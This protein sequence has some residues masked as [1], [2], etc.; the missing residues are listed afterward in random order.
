MRQLTDGRTSFY[1]CGLALSFR[2]RRFVISHGGAVE[3]FVAS[4]LAVPST[5][6]AAVLLSNYSGGGPS[7]IFDRMVD[8]IL[9]SPTAG[10][11]KIDGPPAVEA[12]KQMLAAYQAG[13][14]DRAKLGEE[15]GYWLTEAK[16]RAAS[17]KLKPYGEPTKADVESVNERGGMEVSVVRFTFA[18]GTL[19]G[20][21][22]RTP[23]GKVQ[24]FF[25]SKT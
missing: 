25:V 16:L 12:Q 3:G 23:D 15:F 10:V 13:K 24:Q 7:A 6:S 2:N 4:N 18:G 22:Y 14:V 20:L 1:G 9:P 8:A 17:L 5:R 21:M 11:P 19:R